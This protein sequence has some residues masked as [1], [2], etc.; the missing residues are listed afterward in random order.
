MGRRRR[1]GVEECTAPDVRP[2]SYIYAAWVTL[3]GD[4]AATE[5]DGGTR[6][7][8]PDESDFMLQ[9]GA[10]RISGGRFRLIERCGSLRWRR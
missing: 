6:I 2:D 9:R 5:V 4:I 7:A 10:Q 8:G 1:K 3:V